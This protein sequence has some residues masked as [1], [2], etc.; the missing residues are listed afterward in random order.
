MPQYLIGTIISGLR[1]KIV[2]CIND[3]IL[4]FM[5]IINIVLTFR[6]RPLVYP[7]IVTY[8]K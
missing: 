3:Y 7:T 5:I 1:F 6:F 8:T 4:C 2:Y